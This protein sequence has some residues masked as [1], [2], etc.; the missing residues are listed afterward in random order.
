[1]KRALLISVCVLLFASTVLSAEEELFATGF[2]GELSGFVSIDQ[3]ASLD[4]NMNADEVFEGQGALQLSFMQRE[5]TKTNGDIPGGVFAPVQGP[6]GSLQSLSFAI[7]VASS[8]A[9]AVALIEGDEGPRYTHQF[10]CPAGK[11]QQI[12]LALC[13]FQHDDDSPVDPDGKLTPS[14]VAGIAI[15]DADAFFRALKSPLIFV[16]PPV[17]QTIMLDRLRLLPVA[18]VRPVPDDP[19]LVLLQNY[20]TPLLGTIFLGA[21]DLTIEHEDTFGGVTARI[22]YTVPQSRVFAAI[23]VTGIGRLAGCSGL[24]LR[25]RSAGAATLL[26]SMEERYGPAEDQKASYN[27]FL[28]V[29][30]GEWTT[31]D[32]PFDEFAPDND[33]PDPNGILEPEL[34]QDVMIIDATSLFNQTDVINTLWLDELSAYK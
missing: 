3:Q 30:P 13:D 16:R 23:H 18:P 2:E 1:M 5:Y 21:E 15:I 20:A 9:I 28:R 24:E 6:L 4:V 7:K 26:I 12:T 29:E 10:W 11:W 22:E 31:F 25:I 32:M 19:S 14:E 27:K 17:R 34:I 33:R 8:T